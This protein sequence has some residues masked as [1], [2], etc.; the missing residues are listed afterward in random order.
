MKIL[1]IHQNFPGQF[2]HLGPELARRGHEVLALTDAR[3]NRQSSIRTLR[4]KH[5]AQKVDPA[6]TRLGRNF[7]TMTDRAVSVARAC[8]Q[9]RDREGFVPDVIFGHSGWGE[10]LFLKEVWPTSKLIVYA[11]YYY[12][13]TGADVGFDTEFQSYGFDQVMIAQARAAHLGQA[14]LHADAGLTPTQW[15]ASTYPLPLRKMLTVIHDGVNPEVMIPDP[16][17]S[18]LLPNG[19]VLK[20]GEEVLTFVNRNLEPYRGYHIFMRALPRILAERPNAQVVIVGGDEVSYGA[21]PKDAK[22]WKEKILAEVRDQIDLSRVHFLGKVPYQTF[23]SIMQISRA[24]AY[25]TYPFV[26]S[27]SMIEAMSAGC[28]VVASRTQPVEEALRHGETGL[29]VDF[30]DVDG[31]ATTLIDA[32]ANPSK[33]TH[34]RRAARDH[35]LKHYDIKLCLPRLVSFVE[36]FAG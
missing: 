1:L 13:G 7:T 5:E 3:N 33:Y 24:H 19:T 23:V 14:V 2:L 4:Y 6:A 15:Q 26:L 28:L 11:E 32:L 18:L 16:Q 25:M 21:P 22:G 8:L 36:S 9:L 30:F 27:W 31:W 29:L 35:V 34:L 10:T 17:A 20:A 12:Q